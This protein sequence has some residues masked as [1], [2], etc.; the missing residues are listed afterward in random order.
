MTRLA[1]IAVFLAGTAGY[2]PATGHS[3]APQTVCPPSLPASTVSARPG[4]GQVLVPAGARS[5]LL[6]SY[7]GLNPPADA[8]RL[9][10]TRTVTAASG[11]AAIVGQINALTTQ[12]GISGCPMDD[13][14]AI[15]AIFTYPTA[16]PDPVSIGL[17]GCR[18]VTNGHLTRTASLPPGPT[19]LARLSTLL[20]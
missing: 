16:P 5:L 9:E 17:T 4:A 18:I 8:R 2:A 3:L 15:L 7:H 14:S 1:L 20:G 12:S 11:L 6:C 13:G 19:L 10:R